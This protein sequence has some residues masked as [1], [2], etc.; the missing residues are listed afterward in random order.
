MNIN[1]IGTHCNTLIVISAF[2][3]IFSGTV[4]GKKGYAV[5][6]MTTYLDG[7]QDPTFI[8]NL[9]PGDYTVNFFA[10]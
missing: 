9:G 8:I 10:E 7:S 2:A 3:Y 6:A 4:E 5:V 1:R